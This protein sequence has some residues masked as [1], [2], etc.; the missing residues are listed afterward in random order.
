LLESLR[1]CEIGVAP[2]IRMAEN[3]IAALSE[4]MIGLLEINP[5]TAKSVSENA[6]VL[7][8]HSRSLRAMIEQR[9][10]NDPSFLPMVGV[11]EN[12]FRAAEG[13][14]RMLRDYPDPKM[15]TSWHSDAL[16]VLLCIAD[17]RR[18]AEAV[19]NRSGRA[20]EM[21]VDENIGLM[22]RVAWDA[23]V[24]DKDRYDD[25]IGV[26]GSQ[27][28]VCM[29]ETYD[30]ICKPHVLFTTYA[31]RCMKLR[32]RGAMSAPRSIAHIPNGRHAMALKV[33]SGDLSTDADDII[34]PNKRRE[35]AD[36]RKRL[37]ALSRPVSLDAAVSVDGETT[38]ADIRLA[39]ND[40]E[41]DRVVDEAAVV[42]ILEKAL[43]TSSDAHQFVMNERLG[44]CG[45]D[46]GNTF[47]EIARR[48]HRKGVTQDEVS[49]QRVGQ[50]LTDAKNRVRRHLEGAVTGR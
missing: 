6:A 41:F 22:R 16:L 14:I 40:P 33:M 10:S 4:P 36:I 38:V 17:V 26:A 5:S 9:V 37:L 28:I 23:C 8:E 13:N 7:I 24:M 42:S 35:E 48:L 25:M 11:I 19:I 43:R 3:C 20:R 39:D 49:R 15:G 45:G 44:L 12:G 50:L 2:S 1:I 31:T 21:L 34:N 47:A 30:P 29:D 32:C 46:D 18:E 27:F